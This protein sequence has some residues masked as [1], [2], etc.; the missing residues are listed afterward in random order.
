[1]HKNTTTAWYTQELPQV[2]VLQTT[3]IQYMSTNNV[4][5]IK[6][7]R[8]RTILFLPKSRDWDFPAKIA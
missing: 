6:N 2:Y 7:R 1:M 4:H 5:P 3:N 8:R